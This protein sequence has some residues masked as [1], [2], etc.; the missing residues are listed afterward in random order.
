VRGIVLGWPRWQQLKRIASLGGG[1]AAIFGIFSYLKTIFDWVARVDFV[2][3]R[4]ADPGWLGTIARLLGRLPVIAVA[5]TPWSSYVI[6]I[7]GLS[8]IYW[9]SRRRV[10]TQVAKIAITASPGREA[11]EDKHR[12]ISRWLGVALS[13][14][15]FGIEHATLFG[16]IVHDH[17]PTSDVDLIVLFTQ[18]NDRQIRRAVTLIKSELASVFQTTFGHRLHVTFF[19]S[20]EN[21]DMVEF[22]KVAGKHEDIL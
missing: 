7:V 18:A 20:F 22:I 21:H 9:D 8:L 13:E 6:G 5:L 10:A 4:Q 1:L 12:R 19:C 16:S 11:E 17:Y 3:S 14:R 2:I 15:R